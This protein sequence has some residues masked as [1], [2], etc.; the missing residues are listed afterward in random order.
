M[1]NRMNDQGY[2]IEL[3]GIHNRN[4]ADRFIGNHCYKHII[5]RNSLLAQMEIVIDDPQTNEYLVDVSY[6]HP[7]NMDIVINILRKMGFTGV[8]SVD[9]DISSYDGYYITL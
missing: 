3:S 8:A 1:H 6:I 4:I 9:K 2:W 7:N 5:S